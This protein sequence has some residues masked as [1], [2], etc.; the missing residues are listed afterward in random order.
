MTGR[1]SLPPDRYP[2]DMDAACIPL[3]DAINALPGLATIESCEG[4]GAHQFAI[5]FTA[6]S[7]N[8]L[9]PVVGP[10]SVG[11]PWKVGVHWAN[12]SDTVYFALIG[13]ID[14]REAT[15]WLCEQ[16]AP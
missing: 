12:G 5:F 6:S 10:L 13:P 8:C 7:I 16:L 11:T 14:Y 3:C 1:S 15:E 2:S 4:H 9:R